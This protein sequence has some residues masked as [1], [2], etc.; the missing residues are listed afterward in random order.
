MA[1]F[2][3]KCFEIKNL[4]YFSKTLYKEN[5]LFLIID[6]KNSKINGV[7]KIKKIVK[8]K[9]N[10]CYMFKKHEKYRRGI[11]LKLLT[12]FNLNFNNNNPYQINKELFQ[13]I[14]KRMQLVNF[15]QLSSDQLFISIKDDLIELL[16]IQNYPEIKFM[17]KQL[18][19]K[20][21]DINLLKK[22]I[23]NELNQSMQN[24]KISNF[25]QEI[26]ARINKIF[27]DKFEII[28]SVTKSFP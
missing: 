20:L 16:Y 3:L 28:K 19:I 10:Y 4:R 12:T 9:N 7:F 17:I 22:L 23:K 25:I 21:K 5:D 15:P 1:Y 26:I 8:E 24:I 14:L 2:I 11:D 18:K 6:K 13:K 27:F